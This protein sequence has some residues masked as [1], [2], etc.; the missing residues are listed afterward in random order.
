MAE[1]Q[2][3]PEYAKEQIDAYIAEQVKA[4][5]AAIQQA[6]AA[7]KPQPPQADNTAYE[8]QVREVL[9]PIYGVHVD[10]ANF[11]AADAKDY[12]DF[13]SD[14]IHREYKEE[15]EAAFQL[16]KQ[17]GRPTSRNTL[18]RYI[19][20]DNYTADP[21]KFDERQKQIKQKQLDRASSA[22][23]VGGGGIGREREAVAALSDVTKVD[24]NTGK[25]TMPL[26]D[27]EKA[28]AGMTF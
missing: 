24:P 25:Y 15:V 1:E 16:A 2:D 13:Y 3:Q 19:L 23:D 14:D 9:D 28:L 22:G 12:V 6:E 26:E 4:N 8:K 5:M 18:Y 17:Q 10:A 21:T 7:N 27:M 11:N 20:G